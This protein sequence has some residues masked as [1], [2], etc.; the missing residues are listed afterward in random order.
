MRC[1][2]AE[3]KPER[4]KA[5]ADL[6]KQIAGQGA[7]IP[8]MPAHDEIVPH[9]DGEFRAGDKERTEQAAYPEGLGAERVLH[10][11]EQ[12]DCAAAEQCHGPV[13]VAAGGDLKARVEKESGEECKPGFTGGYLQ[14]DSPFHSS[15]CAA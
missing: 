11:I 6:P 4:R 3:D 12:R 13:R 7:V 1:D 5:R 2:P 15:I 14:A 9:A 10:V 8:D